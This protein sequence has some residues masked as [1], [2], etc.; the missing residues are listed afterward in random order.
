M[1]YVH[2]LAVVTL[3]LAAI[4]GTAV[5]A[6]AQEA[7]PGPPA[8][9]FGA[10][11]DEAGTP[12]P[13]GATI[14]AVVVDDSGTTTVADTIAVST[15]GAYGGSGATDD[16]LRVDSN[17]GQTVRFHVGAPDGP[18]ASETYDLEGDGAGVSELDLTF[19]EGVFDDAADDQGSIGGAPVPPSGG[20]SGDGDA[21]GAPGAGGPTEAVFTVALQDPPAE[22]TAGADAIVDVQVTNEGTQAGQQEVTLSIG[23]NL[24]DGRS[25]GLA[26]G[27]SAEVPLAG[28]VPQS[29]ADTETII[30]VA[31]ADDSDEATVTVRG[32]DGTT[33]SGLSITST[34]FPNSAAPG[35]T[36]EATVELRNDG[37]SSRSETVAYEIAGTTVDSTTVT[38]AAGAT[39]AITLSGAVPEDASGTVSQRISTDG[40]EGSAKLATDSSGSSGTPGFGVVSALIAGLVALFVGQRRAGSGN[41]S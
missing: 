21:G 16:K 1:N 36:A 40:D 23:G 13:E 31:S 37:D 3:V 2:T 12:A 34:E 29:L 30:S 39:K 9:F 11:E 5:T 35:D 14:Y 38:V 4:A 32:A 7:P 28:P 20:D 27:E 17:A 10:A 6:T 8:S 24:E 18:Q 15:S 25:L 41:S 33:G 26:A 19:P 22:V